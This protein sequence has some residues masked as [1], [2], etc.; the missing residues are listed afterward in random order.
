MGRIWPFQGHQPCFPSSKQGR[1]F[2][3]RRSGLALPRSRCTEKGSPPQLN[4]WSSYQPRARCRSPPRGSSSVPG[5]TTGSCLIDTLNAPPRDGPS[6]VTPRRTSRRSGLHNSERAAGAE[7][8]PA[9]GGAEPRGARGVRPP[10]AAR[11]RRAGSGE[12]SGWAAASCRRHRGRGWEGGGRGRPSGCLKPPGS[13]AQ[14]RCIYSRLRKLWETAN[15][16]KTEHTGTA[17][18]FDF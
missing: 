3:Q 11:P 18:Q 6:A 1:D 4:S 7:G 8:T 5:G 17:A 10:P 15:I 2:C 9:S 14:S 16:G 12:R 13:C